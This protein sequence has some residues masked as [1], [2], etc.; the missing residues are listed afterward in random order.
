MGI[1]NSC[2]KRE[3]QVQSNEVVLCYP[4][5]VSRVVTFP[6]EGAT[7]MVGVGV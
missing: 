7:A 4:N 6:S 2:L 5:M 1:L 3:V